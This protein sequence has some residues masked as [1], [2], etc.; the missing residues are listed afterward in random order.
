MA[1]GDVA[2]GASWAGRRRRLGERGERG[3]HRRPA[4]TA[5][6]RGGVWAGLWEVGLRRRRGFG[7][8][9]GGAV[10]GGAAGGA[11][12]DGGGAWGETGEEKRAR[13]N[14]P[15]AGFLGD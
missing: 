6:E 5:A 14:E 15:R 8:R 4:A 1:G 3:G 10:G 2:G 7:R 11:V 9:G 13:G 12:G